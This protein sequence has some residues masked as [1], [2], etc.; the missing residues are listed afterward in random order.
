MYGLGW[1]W[2]HEGPPAY[3]WPPHPMPG[4]AIKSMNHHVLSK[5][6]FLVWIFLPEIYGHN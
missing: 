2:T 1:L 3:A 5:F 6:T 4:M